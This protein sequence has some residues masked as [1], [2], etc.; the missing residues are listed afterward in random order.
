[1]PSIIIEEEGDGGHHHSHRRHRDEEPYYE[2]TRHRRHHHN[3]RRYNCCPSFG[4]GFRMHSTHRYHCAHIFVF[5]ALVSAFVLYLLVALSLPIIKA[6]YLFQLNF[7]AAN[8]PPTT[9]ATN[10]RFG[11]WGFCASNA[12]DLPTIL[13]NHGECTAPTLG[14][15]IPADILSLSGF[16]PEVTSAVLE[17]LTVLLVLHPVTAGLSFLTLLLSIFL[18]SQCFTIMALIS[19][20]ITGII[21][22]VVLAADL[23]IEIVAK[24]KLNDEFGPLLAVSFGPAVWMS[25]AALALTWIGVILLSAVACRCC[26]IRR[27]HGWYGDGYYG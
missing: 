1:M 16:P 24:N 21:G 23:A 26:G 19:G 10:L 17:T 11:V 5:I 14:Y 18:R 3:R 6:V 4:Y 2:E 9:V 12:L 15:T 22:A 25:V 7:T 13:T 27:K 8:Q 20:I